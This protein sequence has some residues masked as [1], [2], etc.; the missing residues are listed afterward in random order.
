MSGSFHEASSLTRV[1]LLLLLSLVFR[2]R[3]VRGYGRQRY[4]LT[5]LPL[6]TP[7]FKVIRKV[8]PL[9]GALCFTKMRPP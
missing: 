6:N 3:A 1:L 2:Y 4:S 9:P 7:W 5:S 8:V